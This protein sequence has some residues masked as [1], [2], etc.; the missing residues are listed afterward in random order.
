MVVFS[1][2]GIESTKSL[3]FIFLTP[4][5]LCVMI[6]ISIHGTRLHWNR[7]VPWPFSRTS[8]TNTELTKTNKT[9]PC[10]CCLLLFLFVLHFALFWLFLLPA[11]TSISSSFHWLYCCVHLGAHWVCL[12]SLQTLRP[13]KMRPLSLRPQWRPRLGPGGL[14]RAP[15]A[16]PQVKHL[17]PKPCLYSSGSI[18]TANCNCSSTLSAT[19]TMSS[20][21][22]C[23]LEVKS[24]TRRGKSKKKLVNQYRDNLSTVCYKCSLISEATH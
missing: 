22:H 9:R 24:E 8:W 3:L 19:V 2:P 18:W 23:S 6:K 1:P 14:P 20:F 15:T 4:C 5:R 21:R 12:C 13:Q 17:Q 7:G 11:T 16:D 10:C